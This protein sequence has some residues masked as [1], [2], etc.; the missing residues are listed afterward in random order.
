MSESTPQDEP[1]TSPDP[2]ADPHM[3]NPREG[4]RASGDEAAAGEVDPDAD[5]DMLNPRTGEQATSGE[6]L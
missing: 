5:P 2:D 6:E 1:M 3:L 4:S